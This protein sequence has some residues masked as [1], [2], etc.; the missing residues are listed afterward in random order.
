[1]AG[2]MNFRWTMRRLNQ[3]GLSR[4][5]L[6]GG[7]LHTRLGDRFLERELWVPSRES[8]ARAFLVGMPV[9]WIPFLP[10]QSVIACA[11]AF[12]V[13][14]NLPVSFLLQFLS[15]PATAIVQLPACYLAGKIVLGTDLSAEWSRVWADPMAIVTGGSLGALYLGSVVLGVG[16]GVAGYFLTMLLWRPKPVPHG[17][18]APKRR[19]AIKVAARSGSKG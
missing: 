4:A 2:L 13:R 3:W 17:P 5:K 9:T 14:G 6:R 11:C 12:W 16:T 15:S 18:P 7:F 19:A 8:L 10:A 1:M